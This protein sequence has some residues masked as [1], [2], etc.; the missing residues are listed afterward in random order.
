MTYKLNYKD[1]LLIYKNWW[2]S[3]MP[4]IILIGWGG[5]GLLDLISSYYPE[6]S[7]PYV[8]ENSNTIIYLGILETV[9]RVAWLSVAFIFD[10]KFLFKALT[11]P[12]SK[13]SIQ[14]ICPRVNWSIYLAFLMPPFIG[15]MFLLSWLNV[16][17]L[18][19]G[20]VA[21][22]FFWNICALFTKVCSEMIF[23]LPL[24]GW[25]LQRSKNFV[26]TKNS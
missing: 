7:Y 10:K 24:L 14:S 18:P 12:Y 6:D 21:L 4:L 19:W 3:R 26:I 13:F 11:R 16:F 23:G 20:P 17:I 5:G 2:I 1:L 15:A 25:L 8:T 22:W 9:L